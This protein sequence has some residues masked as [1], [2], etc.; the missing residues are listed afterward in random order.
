M[1]YLLLSLPSIFLTVAAIL[2]A[3]FPQWVSY[4]E[5]R[6]RLRIPIALALGL[7]AIVSGIVSAKQM[8]SQDTEITSLNSAQSTGFQQL[9]QHIATFEARTPTVPKLA[10][11]F[12]ND[13]I[14]I[15]PVNGAL[16]IGLNLT[17]TNEGDDS[18]YTNHFVTTIVRTPTE[19]G[20]SSIIRVIRR[21]LRILAAQ[22][23]GDHATI[24]HGESK[25]TSALIGRAD[26]EPLNG[27]ALA[28]LYAG[29]ETAFFGMI[30]DV[31]TATGLRKKLLYCSFYQGLMVVE[32]PE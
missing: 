18:T 13:Q 5:H 25:I 19:S 32:C 23:G 2:L 22:A 24:R 17:L 12:S 31:T 4:L 7:L 1:G 10:I 21:Q 29:K 16:L 3:L 26:G 9:N 8:Q 6:P 14:A 11:S 27:R 28:A 30:F 15:L 20:R